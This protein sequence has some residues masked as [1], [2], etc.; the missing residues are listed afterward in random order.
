M[1]RRIQFILA[2]MIVSIWFT[3]ATAVAQE[4]YKAYEMADGQVVWF[5]MT[6]EEMRAEDARKTRA[7][8]IKQRA[9]SAPK[10]WVERI[11]LPE[12]GNFIE[13]PMSEIQ[14]QAARQ[15][16]ALETKPLPKA[17][18]LSEKKATIIEMADGNTVVFYT[19]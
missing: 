7:D 4:G 19:N 11:E 3:A 14:I 1:K 10:Q 8:Q 16:A 17:A 13:F 5:K 12:S 18:S 6:P 9:A 15:K 2:A